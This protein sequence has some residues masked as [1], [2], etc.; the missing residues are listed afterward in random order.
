MCHIALIKLQ[1][2]F[3]DFF[4]FDATLRYERCEG[5]SSPYVVSG[6]TLSPKISEV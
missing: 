5:Q 1:H 6:P 3:F 2:I 4:A